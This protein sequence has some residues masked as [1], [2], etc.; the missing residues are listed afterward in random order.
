MDRRGVNGYSARRQRRG[1]CAGAP[2]LWEA[3]MGKS[4]NP[5][6]REKDLGAAG[7][8]VAGGLRQQAVHKYQN[9]VMANVKSGEHL[10]TVFAVF[11]LLNPGK[12]AEDG[13][14][15][16]L[17]NLLTIEGPGCFVCEQPWTP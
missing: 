9:D 11:Q 13:V 3:L 16:D 10:W 12:A 15:L 8:A 17:E 14:V 5:A 1:M 2:L 7:R 6:K 4:G